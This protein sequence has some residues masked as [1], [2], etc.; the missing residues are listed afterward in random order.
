V[1][2]VPIRKLFEAHLTVSDLERSIRFY[3]DT[4]GLALAHRVPERQVAF[5]WM[6]APGDSM[7][8][9]WAIGSS[10][11]RLRLH[12]AFDVA[13][14]DVIASVDRLRQA[15][16]A[17]SDGSGRTIDEPVVLAWMAA[18]SVYFDDPDGHSLEFIAMLPDAPRPDLGRVPLSRWRA[19]AGDARLRG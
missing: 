11:M 6:G 1:A 9:L 5:F 3:R 16:L 10:P 7:L 2:L 4:L 18:A 12:I 13:L 8:G 19:M 15:G 14:A 17:P